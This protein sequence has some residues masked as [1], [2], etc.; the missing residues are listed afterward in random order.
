MIETLGAWFCNGGFTR[1][2]GVCV[3]APWKVL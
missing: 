1:L 2:S 3:A